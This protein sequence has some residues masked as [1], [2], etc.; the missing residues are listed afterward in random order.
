[1]IKR[2]LHG[3]C[4]IWCIH[5]RWGYNPKFLHLLSKVKT[6]HLLFH[7][8][9][10]FRFIFW[11]RVGTLPTLVFNK[12]SKIGKELKCDTICSCHFI[13]WWSVCVCVNKLLLNG[14]GHFLIVRRKECDSPFCSQGLTLTPHKL[15]STIQ[16]N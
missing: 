9:P 1:M 10:F 15:I 13:C 3:F 12:V 11:E 14:G 8:F 4:D 5:E 16:L 7:S 6:W 2:V